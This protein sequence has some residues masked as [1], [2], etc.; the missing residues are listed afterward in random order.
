MT[1]SRSARSISASSAPSMPRKPSWTIRLRSRSRIVF[2]G[3]T[4]ELAGGEAEDERFQPSQI[5]QPV[6]QGLL[7]GRQERLGG[8]GALQLQQ[9]AQR[10]QA[11]PPLPECRRVTGDGRMVIAQQQPFL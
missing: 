9:T 4:E 8:I 3:E 7:D 11:A 1:R 6:T 5:E 2:T 10:L